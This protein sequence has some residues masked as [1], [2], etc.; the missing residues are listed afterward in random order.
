[1]IV[2]PEQR[3]AE[4]P[5]IEWV[6]HGY[7]VADGLEMRPAEY[8]WHLIFTRQAGILRILV[9]GAL[10]AA[11]PLKYFG[12][13]ETLWLR[14]KV[15]TFMPHLP[16]PAT[17]NREINLPEGSGDNF[18]LQDKVWE[19]PNFENVDTFVAQLVR[20]GA[21]TYDPLI[22]AA[23]RDELAGAA[24][25]T[26]RHR[27]QHSTGL[28]QNYIRQIM[29]AQRAVELLQQGNSIVDTA[30]E[31]GY[32]DQPHLTRSLKRLLGYTPRELLAPTAQAG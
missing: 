12:G 9:V 13:A 27:F 30:Y 3:I 31:L 24:A 19:I 11:R 18:W 25:R 17:L 20:A 2:I 26:I 14:F 15:G 21:L 8:N 1:M 5:Y 23:L 4:S 29:R 22:D 6:A 10:E 16:A 7:T 32:A 28:R